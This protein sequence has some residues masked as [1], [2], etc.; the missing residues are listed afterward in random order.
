MT[1][2]TPTMAAVMPC[3]MESAPRDAPTKRF[4]NCCN[5]AGKAPVR[6]SLERDATSS[7][8][9]LPVISPRSRIALW[10]VATSRIWSFMTTAMLRPTFLLV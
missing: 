10:M 6:K 1:T 4:S 9:K 7:D 8:V 3:R 5:E 2:S